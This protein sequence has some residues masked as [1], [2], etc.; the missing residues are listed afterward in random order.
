MGNLCVLVNNN[1]WL[2]PTLPLLS[3]SA[4]P[5]DCCMGISVCTTALFRVELKWHCPLQ[6][7]SVQLKACL[8]V[9]INCSSNQRPV[10]LCSS[11]INSLAI[12][13]GRDTICLVLCASHPWHC[14]SLLLTFPPALYLKA[15]IIQEVFIA[16]ML[17]CFAL[18]LKIFPGQQAVVHN[19]ACVLDG[20]SGV[21]L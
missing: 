20:F 15:V 19:T 17:L 11:H 7:M 18:W 21:S 13:P 3:H 12:W 5:L 14:L 1:R 8:S 4:S 6:S 10:G 16:M 2:L 9:L